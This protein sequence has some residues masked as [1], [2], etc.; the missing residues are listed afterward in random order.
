MGEA[1]DLVIIFPWWANSAVFK[2]VVTA[3]PALSGTINLEMPFGKWFSF[4][5]LTPRLTFFLLPL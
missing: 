2:T 4:D 3:S 5:L 1:V